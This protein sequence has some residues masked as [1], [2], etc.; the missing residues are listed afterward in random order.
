M[1]EGKAAPVRAEPPPERLEIGDLVDP[2]VA[3]QLL[4]QRGR[5]VPVDRPEGQE[6]RVEPAGQQLLQ[7]VVDRPQ[8]RVVGQELEQIAAHRH[9][10]AGA[11]R[12]HVE[13]AE[14]L[15]ALRLE[16][17]AQ[18]L[19]AG[20]IRRLA[21]GVDRCL[22]R[23]DRHV[24]LDGELGEEAALGLTI[25]PAIGLDQLHR[26]RCAR[27]VAPGREQLARQRLR[28]ATAVAEP[29]AQQLAAGIGQRREEQIDR[30]AGHPGRPLPIGM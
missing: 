3:D 9:Q 18:A 5:A 14:Q 10:L 4:Q 8:C 13:A 1:K 25:L 26:Q 23:I 29:P 21:K 11:V 12:G 7:V 24:V 15:V 28:R 27:G 22:D 6:A 2:F 19:Q 30:V 20:G 17:L 16:R